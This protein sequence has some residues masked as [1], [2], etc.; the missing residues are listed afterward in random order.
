MHGESVVEKHL[1]SR[2]NLNHLRRQAKALLVALEAGEPEAVATMLGH[3]P[4]AAGMTTEQVRRTRFRLADAQSAIARKSGFAS[5]PQ[6]GRHVELLRA[7]EGTWGFISLEIDGAAVPPEGMRS[8][9]LLM[10]GDRFRFECPEA[11]YEGVF[12]ID[13]EALP[14]Q[15][16]IEFV[17]GPEEGNWNFG[18]FRIE[19][20]R[21][22]L[23]LDM[24]GKP[25]PTAFC[26]APGSGHAFEKLRRKSSSRPDDVDGGTPGQP[27]SPTGLCSLASSALPPGPV[28]GVAA[29][30]ECAGFPCVASPLLTRLHGDWTA[31]KLIRD[32]QELPEMMTATGRRSA[33]SNEVKVSFGGQ[34]IFHVLLRVNEDTDPV[35]LDYYHLTGPA[36]GTVQQGIMEWRGD[37]ACFCMAAPGGTRP[38]DFACPK[39]SGQTLSQWRRAK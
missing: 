29:A 15:I 21:L 36:K 34:L 8:S 3:L 4:A 13:V 18:I 11:N 35:Q 7:L 27:W 24:N 19:G 22:D 9:K 17:E 38:S 1:P 10:D 37:E 14:H 5:W 16:D 31:T 26:T 20:D 23:C 39:G 32:G 25:R 6:L 2:P 30:Q 28:D 12:N 33:K